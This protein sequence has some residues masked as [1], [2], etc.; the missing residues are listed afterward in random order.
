[1]K[2]KVMKMGYNMGPLKIPAITHD[3]KGLGSPH[4]VFYHFNTFY[5]NQSFLN[6]PSNSQTNSKIC[7]SSRTR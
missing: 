7:S 3:P 4:I 1:M 5:C 6:N 2:N